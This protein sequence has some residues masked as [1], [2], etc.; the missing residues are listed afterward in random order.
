[1]SR[2]RLSLLC[3]ETFSYDGAVS[4][5]DPAA[6]AGFF[7]NRLFHDEPREVVA[8]AF[9]DRRRRLTGYMAAFAGTLN[10]SPVEPREI[11][12]AAL[13]HGARAIA[14]GHN[15]PSGHPGPSAEDLLFTRRLREAG[16]TV[17]VELLD[18]VVVGSPHEW[19]SLR[20]RGELGPP[21]HRDPAARDPS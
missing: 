1:V 20:E 4:G 17:G 3:E 18:H 15:H 19:T 8:V 9:F 12:A 11:L 7:W 13:L 5:E 14:L 10:R 16:H 21:A 2:C 6:L